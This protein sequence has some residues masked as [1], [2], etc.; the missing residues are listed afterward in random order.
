VASVGLVAARA[1]AG[2]AAEALVGYREV[3]DY[4]ARTG[5]WTHQWTTLRNVVAL[6]VRAGEAEAA[7]VLLGALGTPRRSV[8]V[9]GPDAERLH[10]TTADLSSRLGDRW[11]GLPRHGAG[12][13]VEEVVA[14]ARAALGRQVGSPELSG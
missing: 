11:A 4:F 3:V 1:A 14:V 9:F 10:D 5:N 12:L 2:R 13:A 8:S 6:L 7:A